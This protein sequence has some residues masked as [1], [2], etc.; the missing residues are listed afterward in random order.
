VS[1]NISWH[2]QMKGIPN[3]IYHLHQCIIE[4]KEK[5]RGGI[6]AI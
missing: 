6:F 5:T 4:M 1:F 2:K 3:S